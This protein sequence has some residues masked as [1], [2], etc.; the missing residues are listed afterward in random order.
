VTR[1]VRVTLTGVV[2]GVGF[3]PFVHGLARRLELGGF[4]RNSAAGL[5]AEVEGAGS[6]VD[7]FVTAVVA[8]APPLARVERCAVEEIP[9]AG[10]ARFEIRPSEEAS[11]EFAMISP[12]I[13]TCAAC[14]AEIRN[15]ANRRHG[16]AF[17]NCTDCGPRYTIVEDTPYDR[18]STTMRAFEMCGDCRA[19]YE[20]VGDRRYHAQPNACPRCG[21]SLS[22]DVAEMR[23]RLGLGEI[24]AIKGLGG[25]HLACDAA[26]CESVERLRRKKR[27]SEKPFALMC[28]DA[29]AAAEI[30]RVGAAD[31]SALES[32][33]RPIV[34]MRR[35]DERLAHCAP[36]VATLGVMLPYTPLHHLLFDDAPYR[37]LVMTSGNLSEEPIVV[38]NGEARERLAGVADAVVTHDRGIY[39]RADDSIVRTIEGK[40]RMVRR[41]R[42]FAPR[43]IDLG[44]DCG[45]L[46]AVGADLKNAFCLVKGQHAILSPH[47][48]DLDNYEAQQFFEETLANL[49]KLFRV[50]PRVVAHDLHPL[51]ASTRMALA[52]AGVE[53]VAVQHHHAH[54]A[55]CMAENGLD[56]A[57]IGVAFD[58]TGYGTD[59]KIWGG[60]FLVARYDGFERYAHLRYFP[61]AGG[62]AGVREPWRSALALAPGAEVRG[63][64]ESRARVVRRMLETGLNTVETSS[65]GRVFDAVAAL[66]GLRLEV[67]YEGQA[68][69]ELEA[70]ADAG[71]TRVYP[72][73]GLDFRPAVEAV[74]ADV[75]GGVARSTIA[76]RFHNTVSDGIVETCRRMSV[77]TGLRRVCLSGGTFQNRLL[78]ERTVPL[79]RRAGLEVF[80]HRD[81]PSNDGG[82]ALGQAMAAA[83]C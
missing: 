30:C 76:G 5:V 54:V 20:D 49:R 2:Q 32:R 9:A 40:A 13:A 67:T 6:A 33:E 73:D 8:E 81:A 82:L 11:A 75:R 26:N 68:A 69:I 64:P 14:L 4:A 42:G 35:R 70:I 37:A 80:L 41:S 48:G 45:E 34:V 1:R 27:R 25:F 28:P 10:E 29:E 16:Y 62:D 19:E 83:R 53:H 56:G 38:R 18:P 60:E 59:G 24:L 44:R 71:E 77:D 65:C 3:R 74:A 23:R 43:T 50:S 22:M 78:V 36:G 79:L 55:S 58:G 57:V 21:P 72:R 63:V 51:Y 52:M 47:I 66:I 39:M 12:D 46:L 31:R 61:L 17:T 7:G 15:L